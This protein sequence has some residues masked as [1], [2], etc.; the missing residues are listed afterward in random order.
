MDDHQ[1]H[2]FW[3]GDTG[4]RGSKGMAARHTDITD[5]DT[6]YIP[7]VLARSMFTSPLLLRLPSARPAT[8]P[9]ESA[10]EPCL[11]QARTAGFACG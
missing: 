6:V 3:P 2:S 11:S 10:G 1:D 4:R 5:D 8:P 7:F 9:D